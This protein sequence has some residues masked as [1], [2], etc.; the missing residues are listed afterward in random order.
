MFRVEVFSAANSDYQWPVASAGG[1][2][3]FVVATFTILEIAFQRASKIGASSV[4]W[5]YHTQ[6]TSMLTRQSTAKSFSTSSSSGI[7]K[8]KGKSG[9]KIRRFF[10]LSRVISRRKLSWSSYTCGQESVSFFRNSNSF[11]P[12]ILGP[13][14]LTFT[15]WEC[16]GSCFWHKPTELAHFFLLCSCVYFCLYGPFYCFSFHKFSQQLSAFSLCSS[17]LITALVVLSTVYIYNLFMKV[18][19]SPGV[20]LCGW[21]DLKHQH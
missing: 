12:V 17:G 7:P 11:S 5:Q 15:W 3:S 1:P 6:S 16:Y 4:S 21:L 10:C 8:Y 18:S 19:L 2:E 13:C 9:H 20:A 14:G